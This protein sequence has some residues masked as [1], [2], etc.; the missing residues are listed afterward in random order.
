MQR[1]YR[2]L[3]DGLGRW[4]WWSS[5]DP[6]DVFDVID[7]A[8][9]RARIFRASLVGAHVVGEELEDGNSLPLAPELRP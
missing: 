6:G 1:F 2:C 3:A 8:E 4:R 5:E 7:L 9:A